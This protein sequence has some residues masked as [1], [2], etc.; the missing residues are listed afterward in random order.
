V[1]E[2]I[3]PILHGPIVSGLLDALSLAFALGL[4]GCLSPLVQ[5]VERLPELRYAVEMQVRVLLVVV[6][7]NRSQIL[8]VFLLKPCQARPFEPFPIIAMPWIGEDASEQY[9]RIFAPLSS[10]SI[11]LR[12]IPPRSSHLS[13]L[14]RRAAI[15]ETVGLR[16][17]D[18]VAVARNA[19]GFP[20]NPSHSKTLTRL[21]C[22]PLDVPK[23]KHGSPSCNFS[24][25][26]KLAH[27]VRF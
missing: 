21:S 11:F 27:P 5:I 25:E 1:V 17:F 6:L 24:F 15:D 18:M 4:L 23:L 13:G 14:S 9:R 10:A 8:A 16:I 26:A 22:I 2:F 20:P 12:L 19:L 3:L 7:D